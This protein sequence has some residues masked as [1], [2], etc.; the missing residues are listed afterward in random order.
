M[1]GPPQSLDLDVT[2]A[3]RGHLVTKSRQQ[4][5]V[6]MFEGLVSQVK[7][8]YFIFLFLFAHTSLNLC[9]HVDSLYLQLF[10]TSICLQQLQ[11]FTQWLKEAEEEED[12]A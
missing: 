5:A 9:M 2:E 8:L 6:C 1:D 7:L 4:C 12:R 3:V 10:L 11:Q